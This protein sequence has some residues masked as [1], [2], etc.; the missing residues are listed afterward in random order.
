MSEDK[1]LLERPV[2]GGILEQSDVRREALRNRARALVD[3]GGPHCF[4]HLIGNARR[5]SIGRRE[6]RPLTTHLADDYPGVV[7]RR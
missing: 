7:V 1:C 4:E 2:G 6:A 5:P 3:E